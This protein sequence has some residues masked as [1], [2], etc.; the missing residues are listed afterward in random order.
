MLPGANLC[1][2]IQWEKGMDQGIHNILLHPYTPAQM[3]QA[4]VR[5]DGRYPRKG[6]LV[7]LISALQEELTVVVTPA[8]EGLVCTLALML[9]VG[10]T[11][12]AQGFVAKDNDP[13]TRC[14]IVHQVDRDL[15]INDFYNA[16]FAL[17]ERA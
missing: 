3:S 7:A 6:E 5:D 4:L 16:K 17:S 8:S 9:R 14:A 11:F 13:T 1:T 15:A 10:L 12:D 2:D